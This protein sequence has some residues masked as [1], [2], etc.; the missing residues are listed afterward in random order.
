MRVPGVMMIVVMLVMMG[1]SPGHAVADE[2]PTPSSSVTAGPNAPVL[3]YYYIWFDPKS[4]DRAKVDYPAVGRYSSDDP[5]VMREQIQAAKAAG[6]DGFIVSWK[7]TTMNNRRL[8][9]LMTIAAEEDFSLA[10]IYQGLDFARNPL[11]VDRVAADFLFFQQAFAGSPVFLRIA[12]KPL[13]IFSGTWAYS[14]DDIAKIT[15]PVRDSLQVLST[16]KSVD[17]YHRVADVTDGD[18]YY[19]SSVDPDTHPNY[20]DKL[21]TMRQAIHDDGKTWVAPFSPGFDARLVGGTRSVD[22]KNGATLI[23]QYRAAEQ[24]F[25]DAYGLIS[26]NEFSENTYVEPSI[27]F[28]DRYLTV[29]HDLLVTHTAPSFDDMGDS[30][31]SPAGD[32]GDLVRNVLLLSA[33]VAGLLSV[34]GVL[35]WRRRRKEPWP[36]RRR[37]DEGVNRVLANAGSRNRLT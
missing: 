5:R 32:A 24:S 31:A 10:M 9:V 2:K 17:G 22:R 28:G 8:R 33:F 15:G 7:S 18:A 6:I 12:G 23:T 27:N 30:S 3:A 19:W 14:H 36:P 37:L 20:P 35:A 25:P 21:L 13:T 1:L 16:E 29:L 26:W 11:P 4:W 34:V